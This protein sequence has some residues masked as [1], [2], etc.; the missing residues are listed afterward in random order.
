VASTITTG[1]DPIW[2]LEPH[3][4]SE[5]AAFRDGAA[6]VRLVDAGADRYAAGDVRAGIIAREPMTLTP[7]EGA[8]A[9][10]QGRMVQV[11]LDLGVSPDAATW[12]RAWCLSDVA[13][14]RAALASSRPA[15]SS[16][17]CGTAP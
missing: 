17:D 3:S 5:A 4:L 2:N 8:A 11:L 12:Q 15:G 9:S 10:R 13:D 16:E 1:R 7:I 6:V 14:V